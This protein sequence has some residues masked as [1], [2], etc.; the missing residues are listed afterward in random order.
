[1]IQLDVYGPPLMEYQGKGSLIFDEATQMQVEFKCIQLHNGDIY[2]HVIFLD[3]VNFNIINNKNRIETI[4]GYLEDGRFFKSI[5]DVLVPEWN[6]SISDSTSVEGLLILSQI[7]IE[8]IDNGTTS[9]ATKFKFYLTNLRFIGSEMH[10]LTTN[11]K[12]DILPLEINGLNITIYPDINY[13]KLVKKMESTK[14]STVTSYLEIYHNILSK[15]EIIALVANLCSLLSFAKGTEVIWP[16]YQEVDDTGKVIT[17]IHNSCISGNFGSWELIP[18]NALDLKPFLE[19]TYNMYVRLSNE[20]ELN[21]IIH[22]IV[23]SKLDGSFLELRALKIT[24]AI[25]VLRGRWAKPHGRIRITSQNKFDKCKKLLRILINDPVKLEIRPD[26]ISQMLNKIPELNR[27]SLRDVLTEMVV[28]IGAEVPIDQIE[29]FT[30]TRNKLVH[31]SHFA[32]EDQYQEFTNIIHLADILII[33]L[34]GYQ[35]P[36]IDCRNWRRVRGSSISENVSNDNG[37]V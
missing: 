24:S 14:T 31:E 18:Y 33:T 22:T 34:L 20:Y 2:V 15:E 16:Y 12:R 3:A 32:T 21:E 30:K 26:Q 19:T 5:G 7:K 27:P 37:V 10:W 8:L 25:D 13:N 28:D 23:S 1:M 4:H 9:V 29:A 36:Y 35:G 11:M 17:S 6:Y